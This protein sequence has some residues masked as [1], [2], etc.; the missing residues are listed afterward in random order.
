MLLYTTTEGGAALE[1]HCKAAAVG[2]SRKWKES[3]QT[4][5]T[6]VPGILLTTN[7]LSQEFGPVPDRIALC[8][9]AANYKRKTAIVKAGPQIFPTRFGGTAGCE[10]RKWV[11]GHKEELALQSLVITGS[12]PCRHL[13]DHLDSTQALKSPMHMAG[14]LF[15]VTHWWHARAGTKQLLFSAV[16]ARRL[17][18]RWTDTVKG[19]A[20]FLQTGNTRQSNFCQF[21]QVLRRSVPCG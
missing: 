5:D 10:D 13:G 11:S 8:E 9:E 1:N 2:I 3:C 6:C 7:C 16:P 4:M 21:L 20:D 17:G 19:R 12:M 15:N 14:M 18:R